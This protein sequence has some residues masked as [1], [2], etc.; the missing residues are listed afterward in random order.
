MKRKAALA[1]GMTGL[2][3][4]G[5]FGMMSV[6]KAQSTG[7]PQAAANAAGPK[8]AEEAVQEYPGTKGIPA[9]QLIPAMQ[10]ITASWGWNA[11][12]AT[13]KAH[14]KRMI[15]SPSRRREK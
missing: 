8:K 2:L 5:V 6:A 3:A 13:C 4:A 1:L 15:R 7:S 11:S 12:S 9:D 14:L 10:F